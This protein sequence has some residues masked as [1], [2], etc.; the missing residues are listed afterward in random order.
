MNGLLG[1]CLGKGSGRVRYARAM[2]L[3]ASGQISAAQ[4]EAYRV[5]AAQ[6]GPPDQTFADRGLALPKD[7]TPADPIWTAI[8]EADRYL[9]TLSGPGVAEVRA[10]IK[11]HRAALLPGASQTKGVVETHLALA[12]QTLQGTHPSL[13]NALALVSS[14]L[15]WRANDRVSDGLDDASFPQGHAAA[16]LIGQGPPIQAD[17][18]QFGLLLIAPNVVYRDQIAP[19]PQF[20]APL[21]GPHGWGFAQGGPLTIKVAHQPIWI[22]PLQP[23]VV[24]TGSQPL[25]CLYGRTRDSLQ[26]AHR[27]FAPARPE[28]DDPHLT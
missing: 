21:T 27:V 9:G 26:S 8:D 12:L 13:A 11:A 3:Y 16:L 14:Y 18:F 1:I 15:R 20:Y 17:T 19:A 10:G 23:H 7:P 2:T 6:D 28:Q 24:N 22:P 4:L 25:L 5:A